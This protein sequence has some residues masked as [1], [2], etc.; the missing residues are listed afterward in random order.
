MIRQAARS[1]G[2]REP[3]AG[4]RAGWLC[5]GAA[6]LALLLGAPAAGAAQLAIRPVDQRLE[7][8][9]LG[10]PP[11]RRD[12]PGYVLVRATFQKGAARRGGPL[13]LRRVTREYNVYA[14]T[15]E[16]VVPIVIQNSTT[17]YLDASDLFI[18]P[19]QPGRQSPQVS[20][21]ARTVSEPALNAIAPH[22]TT[23]AQGI[24]AAGLLIPQGRL[25][26]TGLSG[27]S[28]L[29]RDFL[30]DQGERSSR[31]T[32]N[33]R[34]ELA[35]G[36]SGR[37]VR[38]FLL[39]DRRLVNRANPRQLSI[40]TDDERGGRPFVCVE[41]EDRWRGID[42]LLLEYLPVDYTYFATELLNPGPGC[43]GITEPD[44]RRAEQYLAGPTPLLEAD[45]GAER[46][47]TRLASHLPRAREAGGTALL[48][49]YLAYR[50]ES[51]QMPNAAEGVRERRAALAQCMDLLLDTQLTT[52]VGR[53]V[54]AALEA[55]SILNAAAPA[56]P[57]ELERLLGALRRP[58]DQR[59]ADAGDSA[60]CARMRQLVAQ[61]EERIYAAAYAGP[62][63]RLQ[64]FPART[65]YAEAA[66][67]RAALAAAQTGCQRCAEAASAAVAQFD[68][69][70]VATAEVQPLTL[71][72]GA[73]APVQ[74]ELR[75]GAGD[76]VT[77]RR[78]EWRAE[79]NETAAVSAEGLVTARAPGQTSF[80]GTV[81]GVTVTVP[82]TVAAPAAVLTP[83]TVSVPAAPV[84]SLRITAAGAAVQPGDTIEVAVGAEVQLA[85]AALDADGTAQEL[86]I[87]WRSSDPAVASVEPNG[88]IRGIAPGTAM[89]AAAG[90]AVR[91]EVTIRVAAPS[92][93]PEGST[94]S[95]TPA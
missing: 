24:Q 26:I 88:A 28:G 49:A 59:C 8:D 13:G 76:A 27:L 2:D 75:S 16:H 37:N 43:A 50:L 55:D 12:A 78:V 54:R 36:A 20:V 82:V 72:P 74:V 21:S 34:E 33:F 80:T 18:V 10:R 83:D 45:V 30:P 89:V 71:A 68:R 5:A 38:V 77:G 94:E 47:F 93:G 39:G 7:G 67:A 46:G 62:I 90:G 3:R 9:E 60:F 1:Q 73:S 15:G 35:S 32:F 79:E 11:I 65:P 42:F 25:V 41:R 85:A 17:D 29:A 64:G 63:E 92:A 81:D 22:L 14:E 44:V 87:E 31:R 51:R 95:Q 48:D 40:C 91:Q 84:A 19:N 70:R 6:A 86:P 69:V 57:A 23:L 4:V 66:G 58:H 53:Q 56:D 52:E 61:V